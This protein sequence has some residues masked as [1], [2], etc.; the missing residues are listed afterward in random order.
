MTLRIK[1]DGTALWRGKAIGRVA[2]RAGGYF[3][4]CRTGEPPIESR[5]L[6]DMRDALTA[7]MLRAE[8]SNSAT[9]A[10]TNGSGNSPMTEPT[11]APMRRSLE[12]NLVSAIAPQ[13]DEG[14]GK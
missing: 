9:T 12:P 13:R 10:N 5:L 11:R 14:G 8:R 7:R 1:R 3:E 6:S 2:K 4:F